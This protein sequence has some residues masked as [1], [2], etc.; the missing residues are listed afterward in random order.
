M[1]VFVILVFTLLFIHVAS[2]E[3]KGFSRWSFTPEYGYNRFDGD[4]PSENIN[5]APSSL[6]QMTYGAS[7]EFAVTPIW[8]LS[9]NYSYFPLGGKNNLNT[10]NINTDL[11]NS[12]FNTT[13]NFTRLFY[14]Q[15]KSKFYLNGAVGLGYAYYNFNKG[16]TNKGIDLLNG[17]AYSIPLTVSLEYNL[18]KT[19]SF[20]TK[21]Q[22]VAFN[23]DD[24]EGVSTLN[25][26]GNS[27]DFV[28]AGTFFLRYKFHS[29]KK[30]H[31][32]NIKMEVY[33]PDDGVILSKMNS[34]K[35]NKLD[36]EINKLEGI[37]NYQNRLIDSMNVYLANV[38]STLNGVGIQNVK[39]PEPEVPVKTQRDSKG[40]IIK[41]S[42]VNS[43]VSS[44][45][46]E[47]F[48]DIPAI[49][50]DFNK[51]ELDD[52]AL[53]AIS[54]IAY[55]LKSDPSLYIEIKGY[56]DNLDNENQNNLLSQRRSD[57]VKA[58]LVNYWKI[59]YNHIITSG[60]T[61]LA[62]SGFKS[63]PNRR[64]DVFFVKL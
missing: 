61:N 55:K 34:A 42:T 63:R 36:N 38:S 18:S 4:L 5:F 16:P 9:L 6:Q 17:N 41:N 57:R 64:C 26:K 19:I 24:L 31:L 12:T 54:K 37:I 20:G 10:I 27:N 47:T 7:L 58:E 40:R 22:Y 35:I 2:P 46:K 21:V 62:D 29:I 13:V 56:C 23:K 44:K 14:P 11:Y 45:S 39:D 28:G 8:G 3:N 1:K 59:P 30:D 32:R 52:K 50:F 49:Y 48:E 60:K 43:E 25:Y 51:T 53:I 15:S 33:A